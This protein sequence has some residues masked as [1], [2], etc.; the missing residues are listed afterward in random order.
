MHLINITFLKWTSECGCT[1]IYWL[2][3]VLKNL[4]FYFSGCSANQQSLVN[5]VAD[6]GRLPNGSSVLPVNA[7]CQWNIT[8]PVG[9]VVVIRV[10]FARFSGSCSDEHFMIHDG[11]NIIA[12][13]C[14]GT[15]PRNTAFISS[16]RSLFL[17]AKTGYSSSPYK[18]RTYYYISGN[19]F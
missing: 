2:H 7:T 4:H 13:Y 16:G 17:E 18:M 14:N 8:A 10:L 15:R 12:Q 9:K 11:P 1:T 5:L 19:K 6:R 3:I